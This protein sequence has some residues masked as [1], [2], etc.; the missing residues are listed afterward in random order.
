MLIVVWVVGDLIMKWQMPMTSERNDNSVG[1]LSLEWCKE[2]WSW[3]EKM[4]YSQRPCII[5]EEFLC[6]KYLERKSIPHETPIKNSSL[7][8][9]IRNYITKSFS[10]F[11]PF[12]ELYS[13]WLVLPSWSS[14]NGINKISRIVNQSSKWGSILIKRFRKE[15]Q[16][17]NM[18]YLTSDSIHNR[19]YK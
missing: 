2:W 15:L 14:L 4:S 17:C 16:T 11:L 19:C 3:S 7:L 12:P 13:C 1:E 8:N 5:K 18:S 6:R 10:K 9:E